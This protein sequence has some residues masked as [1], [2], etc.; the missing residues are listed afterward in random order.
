MS[1]KPELLRRLALLLGSL[2]LANVVVEAALSA[3]VGNPTQPPFSTPETRFQLA[4]GPV[5]RLAEIVAG[6]GLLTAARWGLPPTDHQRC[7]KRP[8]VHAGPR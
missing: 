5:S 4:G 1:D 8:N 2:I 6:A 3:L 7:G